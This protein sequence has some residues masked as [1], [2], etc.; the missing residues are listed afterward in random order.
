MIFCASGCECHMLLLLDFRQI[1][2]R[3]LQKFVNINFTDFIRTHRLCLPVR[4]NS[5]V[6]CHAF[7]LAVHA[8]QLTFLTS[9]FCKFTMTFIALFCRF[10]NFTAA[11]LHTLQ[12][13]TFCDQ[14]QT[15]NHCHNIDHIRTEESKIWTKNPGKKTT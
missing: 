11:F 9:L 15:D 13:G 14:H 3:L 8:A 7:H 10:I 5:C 6:D 1:G 12:C 2:V 4:K